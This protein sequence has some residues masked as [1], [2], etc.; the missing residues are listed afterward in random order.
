[1][2]KQL[3]LRLDNGEAALTT[4]LVEGKL[5]VGQKL[6]FRELDPEDVKVRF[7]AAQ[8]LAKGERV[9][10]GVKVHL[11]KLEVIEL[12]RKLRGVTL[13][14][15]SGNWLDGRLQGTIRIRRE[16]KATA[17]KVDPNAGDFGLGVVIKAR[18]N[19]TDPARVSQ[20]R[21]SLQGFLPQA[22]KQHP[23]HKVV[24]K[25]P[26]SAELTVTRES[27]QGLPT[28]LLPQ[29]VSKFP[30]A[31]EATQAIEAKHPEI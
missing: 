24:V 27:V 9:L 12:H 17:K 25:G 13:V 10:R 18:M 6:R 3:D 16:E 20:L 21:L 26:K 14:D 23:R 7:S 19:V 28:T 4:L 11:Y 15:A 8:I 5:R 29:L 1:M 30:K 31:L 2:I 22:L